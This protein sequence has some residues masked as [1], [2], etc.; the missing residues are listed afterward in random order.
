MKLLTAAA[1]NQNSCVCFWTKLM[2]FKKVDHENQ[3]PE[4]PQYNL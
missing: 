1:S 2:F 4:L 3:A